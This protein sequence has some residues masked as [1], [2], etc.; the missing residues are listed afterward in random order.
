MSHFLLETAGDRQTST[1]LGMP[2][3]EQNLHREGKYLENEDASSFCNQ[4]FTQTCYV[5]IR[6]ANIW[7]MK[8][9]LFP[10]HFVVNLS[11][12]TSNLHIR[13][14]KYLENEDAYCPFLIFNQSFTPNL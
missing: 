6:E 11:L 7:K 1:L 5:L 10:P 2:K 8:M 13:E 9:L 14:G 12:Q 4:S 3:I